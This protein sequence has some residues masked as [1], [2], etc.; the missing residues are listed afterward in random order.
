MGGKE[1]TGGS[2]QHVAVLFQFENLFSAAGLKSN[3]NYSL[4]QNLSVF[5]KKSLIHWILLSLNTIQLTPSLL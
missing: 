4:I 1:V 2:A 3:S 5:L